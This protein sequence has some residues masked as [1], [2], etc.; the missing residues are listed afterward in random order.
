MRIVPVVL[1]TLFLSIYLINLNWGLSVTNWMH[2]MQSTNSGLDTRTGRP[3]LPEPPG[4]NP[5]IELLGDLRPTSTLFAVE[6]GETRYINVHQR[7]RP[8]DLLTASDGQPGPDW[9]AIYGEAR[10]PQRIA[11]LC[12]DVV[13]SVGSGC[14][15]V[16]SNTRSLTADG[17][18]VLEARLAYQ[19]TQAEGTAAVDSRD[20]IRVAGTLTPKKRVR[21]V[22]DTARNRRLY[23]DRAARICTAMRDLY[24]HCSI[25]GLDLISTRSGGRSVPDLKVSFKLALRVPKDKVTSNEV[26]EKLTRLIVQ[27]SQ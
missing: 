10:A 20:A 4:Q 2:E 19:T 14:R 17:R 25:S 9:E 3:D 23:L 27:S 12:Q 22:Q 5:F 16:T 11:E 13:Q 8:G 18:Y 6:G 7:I 24:G 21:T 26:R 1:G 15:L